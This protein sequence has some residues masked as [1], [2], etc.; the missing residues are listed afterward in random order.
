MARV[1]QNLWFS[2]ASFAAL[3]LVGGCSGRSTYEPPIAAEPAPPPPHAAGLSSDGTGLLGGPVDKGA[4]HADGL[5]TYR[6]ADGMQ[7]TAMRPIANPDDTAPPTRL[8]ATGRRMAHRGHHRVHRQIE[9]SRVQ[10]SLPRY[11]P[12]SISPARPHTAVGARPVPQPPHVN[13]VTARHV[14]P[15]LPLPVHVPTRPA[16]M[17]SRQSQKDWVKASPNSEG[18]APAPATKILDEAKTSPTTSGP[19]S[20]SVAVSVPTPLPI[21]SDAKLAGLQ[22]QLAPQ[23]AKAA[24]LEVPAGL[25]T[26]QAVAAHLTLPTD[27]LESIQREAPKHGLGAAAKAVEITATLMGDGYDV[28]PD[29]AQTRHL[30][31][32]IAPDFTWQIKRGVGSTGPLRADVQAELVGAHQPLDFALA[33]V[34]PQTAKATQVGSEPRTWLGPLDKNG[35]RTVLGAFLVLAAVFIAALIAR[36][37]EA[38]RRRAERRQK[39]TKLSEYNRATGPD[40]A[41]HYATEDEARAAQVRH[42]D[43]GRKSIED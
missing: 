29:G 9:S 31:S 24:R 8:A 13:P 41:N 4:A 30:E 2:G 36:N 1:P 17:P 11:H 23:V 5:I 28:R 10:A 27:L 12:A 40:T 43:E 33:S 35:Q 14:T 37:A 3:L 20:Q 25:I 42:D 6:R 7:V 19:Y 22:A 15:T 26:G 34:G 38:Q 21:P 32:G 16:P 39:F 18:W